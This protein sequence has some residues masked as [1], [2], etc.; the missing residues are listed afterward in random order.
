VLARQGTYLPFVTFGADAGLDRPSQYTPLGAA[1]RQLEYSYGKHFPDPMP[2]VKVGFNFLWELDIWRELRNA[3]DAAI[4]RSIAAAERRNAFVT[5]LVAEVAEN[6][7]KL[8]ALDQRME[9]LDRT[10][11][12]Q[13]QSLEISEA[14]KAAGRGTELPVQRFQAEVRKNQSEKL[15][16][17]QEIIETENRINSSLNRFPQP[18][19]RVP[20][21]FMDLSIPLNVGMPVQLLLNRPDVRQ[22]EHEVTAAGL[23]VKS[24]RAHFFPSVSIRSGVGFEAFN[25]AYLFNPGALIYNVAGE[26]VAPVINKKAIQAEYIGANARQLQAVYNYQKVI[27][28]AFTEVVNRVSKAENYRVSLEIKKQ[29]LDA[30]DASVETAGKLFQSARVEY[31]EVLFAQRDMLEARMVLIETKKEQLAAIVTA[32]Q[33]LGGGGSALPLPAPPPKHRHWYKW[34]E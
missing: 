2:D 15:I 28:D 30:L 25:P 13:Q 4:Q 31:I 12:L 5:K 16:V 26:L 9:V 23:D 6:Y 17:Q 34:W 24:A 20:A 7:F 18:I 14:K 19:E 3:R 10:I 32:Y 33:A 1:E 22:A 29:Q 27:L 21:G 8:M 11:Q